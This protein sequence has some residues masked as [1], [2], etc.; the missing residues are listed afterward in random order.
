MTDH[1]FFSAEEY[2]RRLSAVRMAIDDR[3]LKGCLV[4]RPENI[5]YLTGLDYQGYF[6]YQMLVVPLEG[7]PVLITRA[8]ER[9]TVH[10]QVSDCAAPRLLGWN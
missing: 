1:R 5:Y 2:A 6:A 8:M 9:A 4:S 7:S 3:G 10:D